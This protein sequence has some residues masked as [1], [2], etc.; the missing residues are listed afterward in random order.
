MKSSAATRIDTKFLDSREIRLVQSLETALGAD[1]LRLKRD[2]EI[3]EIYTNAD[4]SLW[5]ERLG[6]GCQDTGLVLSPAD[7]RRVI[8][9]VAGGCCQ[10]VNEEIP[11]ISAELPGCGSRFQG[12]L[13]PVVEEPIFA[14]R[15]KAVK[16]FTLSDYVAAGIMT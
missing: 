12:M 14:I 7:R 9:L 15:K 8:E 11:A 2:P 10:I 5:Y 3:V 1:I 6:S 13:P 4:G 16:I